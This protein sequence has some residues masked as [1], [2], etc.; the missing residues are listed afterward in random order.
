MAI[1]PANIPL[2]TKMSSDPELI[3][4]SILLHE[5]ET[6]QCPGQYLGCFQPKESVV[7]NGLGQNPSPLK[8]ENKHDSVPLKFCTV[9]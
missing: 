1:N 4:Y 5:K 9:Q 3:S 6:Q 8:G 7:Y 2:A